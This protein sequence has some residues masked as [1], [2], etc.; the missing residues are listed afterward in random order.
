MDLEEK[1]EELLET[2]W[3]NTQEQSKNG[4]PLEEIVDKATKTLDKLVNAGYVTVRKGHLRLTTLGTPLA[5]NV[6]RRHRLA[7]RLMADVLD[8]SNSIMH[9]KACKFEHILDH[10]L[11]D[12]ICTLLGHPKICPHGKPIPTGPCC[13][14]QRTPVTNLVSPLSRLTPKQK[15][16]VAY[17][18]APQ[19]NQL[20]KLMVMG[21]LPGGEI[22]LMQNF[23]SYVFRV[24]ETQFAV[25]K[26][27]ADAIYVRPLPNEKTK[28]KKITATPQ[29]QHKKRR[30][31]LW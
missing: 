23:P 10:G 6:I 29:S 5:R 27:I 15:G 24:G 22:T 1:S 31:G 28:N 12:S 30:F 11:D 14:Q 8:T 7:E 13:L 2:I 19:I 26:E 4:I 21:I 18:H 16:R 25:D 9:K 3:V 20:Q 17:V